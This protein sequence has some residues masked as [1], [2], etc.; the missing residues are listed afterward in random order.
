[1]LLTGVHKNAGK[2]LLALFPAG[3]KITLENIFRLITS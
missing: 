3:I 2:A 1:M